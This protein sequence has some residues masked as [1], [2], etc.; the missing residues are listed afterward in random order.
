MGSW[1]IKVVGHGIHHN[2]T[3]KDADEM[4][5]KF[6]KALREAGHSISEAQ[7]ALHKSYAPVLEDTPLDLVRKLDDA[8]QRERDLKKLD[9]APK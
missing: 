3:E 1:T 5:A 8:A 6:V 7:L 9:E 4:A 2:G